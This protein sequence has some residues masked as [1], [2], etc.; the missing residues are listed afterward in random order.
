MIKILW[1]ESGDLYTIRRGKEAGK[2]LGVQVDSID[3]FDIRLLADGGQTGIVAGGPDLVAQYDAVIMRSFMPYVSEALTV[4]RLFHT[5]G[6][7]VVDASMADEGYAM[8][9]MHDYIIL[10][11]NGVAVPRTGQFFDPNDAEAFA[12][13][14]GYPCILKGIHG[15][16]GRHVHK[17]D[18]RQELRK[19]LL[20]YKTGEIMV[21][22]FLHAEQDYRVIVVG[23]RALPV[24]VTRKPRE[25]DFRTNFEFNEEVT[26]H[27][28]SE[29]SHLQDVAERAARALRREFTGVDIRCRGST[30]LVLEANRRPGFKGFEQVTSCDVAGAFI[31]YVVDKCSSNTHLAKGDA[32]SSPPIKDPRSLERLDVPRV[33]R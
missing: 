13:K 29:A 27:P 8:S 3:V 24:Y 11:S 2:K 4:A 9:K 30:P 17:V 22:E 10:A 1:F 21:Q 12:E 6:K 32:V 19:R 20:H 7:V 26:P 25:G 16:E 33:G 15:S 31:Q 28:L 5:A 18:S 14:L 23:Y